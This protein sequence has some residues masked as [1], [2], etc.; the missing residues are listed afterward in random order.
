MKELNIFGVSQ[1]MKQLDNMLMEA[2]DE[3][4]AIAIQKEL[5]I[6]GDK[7][8]EVV[9]DAVN[10]SRQYQSYVTTIEERIKELQ[11]M[12]KFYGK[13]ADAL[14]KGVSN[15]MQ[16]QEISEIKDPS[17]RLSFRKSYQAKI[18]NMSLIPEEYIR[19]KVSYEPDLTAIKN[20][21]LKEGIVID[22]A[23]VEEVKNLQVK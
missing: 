4:T 7:F 20:A 13:K 9:I 6:T 14:L 11:E 5:A 8:C 17:T 19:K 22:G 3:E 16:E 12:K 2:S 23:H 1:R 15:A 21:I 10:L 18:D